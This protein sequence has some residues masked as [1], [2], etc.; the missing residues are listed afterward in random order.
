M[1]QKFTSKDKQW[2]KDIRK[3]FISPQGGSIKGAVLKSRS[4]PVK[5]NELGEVQEVH[6]PLEL[7]LILTENGFAFCRYILSTVNSFGIRSSGL[8][9]ARIEKSHL[10]KTAVESRPGAIKGD[11]SGFNFVGVFGAGKIT[12]LLPCSSHS[13]QLT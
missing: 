7:I 8:N 12:L 4:F 2:K 5:I 10:D 6:V 3:V 9:A 11:T 1:R 13:T